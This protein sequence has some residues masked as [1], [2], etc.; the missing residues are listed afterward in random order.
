MQCDCKFRT[1]NTYYPLCSL[2]KAP[3][4][5]TQALEE[6]LNDP[7][8]DNN[9]KEYIEG[10]GRGKS[11]SAGTAPASTANKNNTT[12]AK[13][14]QN[15]MARNG[16]LTTARPDPTNPFNSLTGARQQSTTAQTGAE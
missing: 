8:F 12:Q 3:T 2:I 10:R 16:R 5:L 1:S 6:Y 9:R 7:N 14:T 4:G 15:G 13:P 11:V